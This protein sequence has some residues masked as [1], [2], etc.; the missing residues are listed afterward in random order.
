MPS[1]VEHK[2]GHIFL[3][4]ALL[5]SAAGVVTSGGQQ[6]HLGT[7]FFSVPVGRALLW[8]LAVIWLL[9]GVALRFGH[10][11]MLLISA[12]GFLMLMPLYFS[13]QPSSWFDPG[14]QT[15]C[16]TFASR[17]N[18]TAEDCYDLRQRRNTMITIVAVPTVVAF[19]AGLTLGAVR[20][21]RRLL[22][23]ADDLT[24]H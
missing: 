21:R 7:W 12:V 20:Q 8:T 2:W 24:V 17:I 11:G 4:A 6:L 18:S 15:H 1:S 14:Y 16:P 13:A 23:E 3:W 22:D 10:R 5:F 19:V 9:L